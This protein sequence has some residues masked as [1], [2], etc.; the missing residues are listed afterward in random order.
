MTRKPRV[1]ILHTSFV[2]INNQL[3]IKEAFKDLLPDVEV[4]DFVD[5][6]IL[7][8]VQREGITDNAVERMTRM[9]EAAQAAGADIIFSACSS[10]GPTIDTVRKAVSVPVVKIDDGMT[11]YAVEKADN[12][13]VLATVPTTLPPTVALIEE[14]AAE[15]GKE[16]HVRQRLAEGA[17]DKLMA[18]DTAGHDEMV[19]AQ[20]KALAPQVDLLVL[21]QASMARLAPALAEATGLEVLS[22]PRLGVLSVK[23]YLEAHTE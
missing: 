12:I 8:D 5:S 10:L 18:G 3:V 16:V 11:R 21:A 2:F 1:A 13:G 4:V 7:A 19:M 20:A 17:F 15:L 22:S 6:N 14:K 23:E 9:A